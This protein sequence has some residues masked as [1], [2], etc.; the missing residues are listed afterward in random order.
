[1]KALCWNGVR[2]LKVERIPDPTIVNP[3]D[4]IVK[5][6]MSSVCGSDLH[7]INGFVPSMKAGDVIGHEFIGEIVAI[8]KE[9][10]G[11]QVGDRVV[12]G[13]GCFC[14]RLWRVPL[15]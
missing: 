10:K 1:M 5:V 3:K 14:Y 7:L 6:T 9:V 2:D 8:G 4:A 15:L 12:P 11:L 13:G